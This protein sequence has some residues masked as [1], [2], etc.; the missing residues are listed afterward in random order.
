M[1]RAGMAFVAGLMS[2]SPSLRPL[3]LRGDEAAAPA[4]ERVVA[5]GVGGDV[6]DDAGEEGVVPW[7]AGSSQSE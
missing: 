5:V 2:V 1:T 7:V 3:R 4:V 6:G